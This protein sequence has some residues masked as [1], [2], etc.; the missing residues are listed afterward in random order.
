ME[1]EGKW[2]RSQTS[3]RLP[4][5]LESFDEH[6][7]LGEFHLFRTLQQTGMLSEGPR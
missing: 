3:G 1:W 5:T 4:V 2:K 7:A 6:S